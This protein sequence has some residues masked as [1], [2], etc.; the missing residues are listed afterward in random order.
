[1]FEAANKLVGVYKTFEATKTI[2]IIPSLIE[3]MIKSKTNEEN[4]KAVEN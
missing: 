3:K 1:M 2:A 4:E